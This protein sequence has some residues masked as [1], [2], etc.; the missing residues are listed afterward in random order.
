MVV[1]VSEIEFGFALSVSGGGTCEYSPEEAI[2]RLAQF[3]QHGWAIVY[4]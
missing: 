4:Q 1:F 2:A 3:Y